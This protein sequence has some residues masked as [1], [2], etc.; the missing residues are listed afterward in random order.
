MQSNLNIIIRKD[1]GTTIHKNIFVATPARALREI[2]IF[3]QAA[4]DAEGGKIN[5]IS[6]SWRT[7]EAGSINAEIDKTDEIL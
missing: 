5:T 3:C 2:N 1:C 7:P 4:L 6:L